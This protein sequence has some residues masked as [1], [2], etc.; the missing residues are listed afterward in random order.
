[1]GG[2]GVDK[3]GVTAG[4]AWAPEKYRVLSADGKLDALET[5]KKLAGGYAE[6]DKRM[7]TVGLPPE[8]ADKYEIAATDDTMKEA[9]AAIV[10]APEAKEILGRL[11]AAGLSNKQ[12][13]L[14]LTEYASAILAQVEETK[15]NCVAELGKLPGGAAGVPK[16]LKEGHRAALVFGERAGVKFEEIEK[17]GLANNPIFCRIMGAIG[18]ELPEDL[19]G[20]DHNGAGDGG[21]SFEEQTSELRAEM[22]KLDIHDPKRKGIQAKLDAL[23]NRKYP[24]TKPILQGA[25]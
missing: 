15:D 2:A 18:K 13:S 16:L 25:A 4:D 22:A 12:A 14:V 20:L 1:M 23:Y 6:L 11:H 9:V 24:Q 10:A 21:K 8:S 5:G 3:G 17:A 7:K 19:P